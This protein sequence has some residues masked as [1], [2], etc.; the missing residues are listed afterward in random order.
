MCQII[1]LKHPAGHRAPPQL[2]MYY[3]CKTYNLHRKFL[4][5]CLNMDLYIMDSMHYAIHG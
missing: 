1:Q 2:E 3:T 4:H 5:S